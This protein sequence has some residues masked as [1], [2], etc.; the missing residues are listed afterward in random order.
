MPRPWCLYYPHG[1]TGI[2]LGIKD[3]T[4]TDR[5]ASYRDLHLD[6]DS[7]GQLRTKLYDKTDDFNFPIVNFPFI[8]S[9]IQAATCIWSVY[10]SVDA[11]FQSLWVL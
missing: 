11:I 4:E 7:E 9:N 8:C 2:K 6:I 3:T 10:L 5:S 1:V